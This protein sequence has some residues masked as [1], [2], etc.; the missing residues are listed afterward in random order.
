MG[1]Q[2]DSTGERHK[3]QPDGHR[4]LFNVIDEND[5]F[6]ARQQLVK[7]FG[8]KKGFAATLVR[9][10]RKGIDVPGKGWRY[11]SNGFTAFLPV[12]FRE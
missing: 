6:E 5:E 7:I 2:K 8:A 9:G 11:F 12:N 10:Y 4:H 1:F 3:N